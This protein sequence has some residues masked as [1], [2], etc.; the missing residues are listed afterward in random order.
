MVGQIDRKQ[1]SN[2]TRAL[3]SETQQARKADNQNYSALMFSKTAPVQIDWCHNVL[4]SR[5][6]YATKNKN[7]TPSALS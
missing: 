7:K 6:I 3:Q 5:Q 2:S 1:K 4:L